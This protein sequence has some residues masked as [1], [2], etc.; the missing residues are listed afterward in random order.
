MMALPIGAH[1]G[2]WWLAW[3]ADPIALVGVPLAA[4][5]YARGLRSLGTPRRFHGSWR[6]AAFYLGLGAVA[7]ALVSPLDRL[8]DGLFLAHMGQHVLLTMVAVP[9]I[10]LGAPIIPVLRGVPRRARR[11]VVIPVLRS[12]PVRAALKTLAHPVVGWLLFVGAFLGWHLP[13]AY[14]AALESDGLHV[15]EHVSF[16]AGAYLFWRT[17]IDPLPLRPTLPYLA[18][19]PYL[20]VTLVPNF[21]LGA[22]LAFSPNPW[23]ATYEVAAPLHGLTAIEDQEVGG[24]LMWIAGS[25]IIGAATLINLGLAVRTEQATQLAREA[26]AAEPR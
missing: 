21:V 10:L 17:A 11:A 24:V 2:P 18:R 22:F 1:P 3:S 20:F 4:L 16:A 19:V 9:L 25:F 14:E 26:R 7:A 12:P 23:Y 15:L 6:P 8:A 13:L 5:L